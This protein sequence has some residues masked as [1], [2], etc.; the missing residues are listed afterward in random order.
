MPPKFFLKYILEIQH[1]YNHG[2][3]ISNKVKISS[4]IGQEKETLVTASA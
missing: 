1:A 2:Q 4:K 3:N